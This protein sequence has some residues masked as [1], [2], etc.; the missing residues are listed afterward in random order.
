MTLKN[1]S[2]TPTKPYSNI[3]DSEYYEWILRMIRSL[4]FN[5]AMAGFAVTMSITYLY[6][7]NKL[8]FV[9]CGLTS[10][11]STWAAYK[12]YSRFEAGK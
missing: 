3:N 6:D 4:M 2:E 1:T 5:C 11:V 9:V 8:G 7:Q 12:T 10:V